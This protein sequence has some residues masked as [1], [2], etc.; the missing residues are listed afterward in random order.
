MLFLQFILYSSSS[1]GTLKNEIPV[2][3]L[4]LC[5]LQVK[6]FSPGI[7]KTVLQF[8]ASFCLYFMKARVDWVLIVFGTQVMKKKRPVRPVFSDYLSISYEYGS[9]CKSASCQ[10]NVLFR[11][12][13]F[14]GLKEIKT[15]IES[16]VY[17]N[18]KYCP[19]ILYF[20]N[21]K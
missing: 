11:L 2:A 9:I 21:Q 17:P 5:Q 8:L 20:C 16:F 12:K 1:L 7:L 18:F 15:L 19:L 3:A 10:L 14:L 6:Q 4:E 13:L